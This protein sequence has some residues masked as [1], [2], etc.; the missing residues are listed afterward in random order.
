MATDPRAFHPDIAAVVE[1]LANARAR[2][3][4]AEGGGSER[5]RA[6]DVTSPRLPLKTAQKRPESARS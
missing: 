2:R 5:D 6:D 3:L 4:A 1:I